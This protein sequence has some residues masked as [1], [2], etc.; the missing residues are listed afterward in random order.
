M[1]ARTWEREGKNVA[2]YLERYLKR[3]K[4]EDEPMPAQQAVPRHVDDGMARSTSQRIAEI[5]SYADKRPTQAE[6]DELKRGVGR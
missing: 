4:W 5:N 6:L 2:P 1:W 3:R